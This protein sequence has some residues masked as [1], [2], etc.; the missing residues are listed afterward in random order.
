MRRIYCL[1]LSVCA[2]AALA[3][4]AGAVALAA[5][6][7][8]STTHLAYVGSADPIK[9]NYGR[10]NY[11]FDTVEFSGSALSGA[12]VLSVGDLERLATDPALDLGHESNYSFLT[13][14]AVFSKQSVSG[15]KLYDLLVHLGLDQSAPT[16][17]PVRVYAADGYV[18]TRTLAQIKEASRYN[19]Y[20]AKGDSTV[21]V[22]GVPVLLSYAAGG[23]PLIGPTGDD[24]VSRVFTW[25]DGYDV[26][27]DNAGG[28]LRLTIGQTSVDD[29]NARLNA[30]W[31]AK[32]VVG[33]PREPFHT[34]SYEPLAAS[35][36]TVDVYDSADMAEPIQTT[37]YTVG[38]IEALSPTR[39][40]GNYYDDG[41]GAFYRGADLWQLLGPMVGLPAY[42]GTAMFT[43]RSGASASVSLA[44]LRNLGGHYSTYTVAR[45][46]VL[47]DD[48]TAALTIS[49][50]R[51]LLAFTKNGYPLVAEVGDAG[52]LATGVA[53]ATVDNAGG[54]L[55]LLLPRNGVH[56]ADPVFL[57]DVTNVRLCVDIPTDVHSGDMYGP[58][59]GREISFGGDGLDAPSTLTVADLERRIE[60]MVTH[61][62]GDT[63]P[64]EGGPSGLY[65]GI[66]LLQ[67]LRSFT[68]SRGGRLARDGYRG[69][70]GSAA[71]T[72]GDLE[73]ADTPVLLAFSRGGVPLV[74][75]S[76]SVGYDDEA[77]NSGG[78]I[79][80]V[81]KTQ[82][83][84]DVASVIV[85]RKAGTWT[86]VDSPYSAYLPTALTISG[87]EV[88][89]TTI[90][91]LRDLEALDAVR[92]S[93][94]A[95]KGVGAY[96]GAVLR[97]LVRAN[98]RA[99]VSRPSK[100]TVYGR[101]GYNAQ[102]NVDTVLDGIDSSYQPGE[103]RD[104][105]LAYSKNGLP[106]V[107]SETSD[108]YSADAFNDGGPIR[109]IVENS[110]SSWVKDVRAIVVGEGEPIYAADR[111]WSTA[112]RI[113]APTRSQTR[114]FIARGSKL[115]LRAT[116]RPA[117][118]TDAV[119][120]T[121]SNR[122][123]ARV[124]AKGVV[125]ARARGAATITVKTSSGRS[126]TYRVYVT[127]RRAA[128]AIRLP[129][130]KTLRVGRATRIVPTIVPTVA[131]SRLSWRSS[132][133]RVASVDC[134]GRVGAKRRGATT[135]TVRTS[136]GKRA[137]CRVIVR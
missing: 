13:N 34:G 74:E 90:L 33:E 121:S 89:R 133:P 132:A 108:G 31:V 14:G 4:F 123:V 25:D 18:V 39:M 114:G 84:E 67:L 72:V 41:T 87:S 57:N 135:I 122:T 97:D 109:L 85:T 3:V 134:T 37:T 112:V 45:T 64:V 66:D 94:A 1:I 52:Y 95:S 23:V 11:V 124:S 20:V 49:G 79:K 136:N 17:T 93:F 28:P 12:S 126:D 26:E 115:R 111:V 131:T 29:F 82:S 27:A 128:T 61:D 106:L 104:V 88:D 46:A 137:A 38:E 71:F 80:L 36:L 119:S 32:V 15:I 42:Q 65:H 81:S 44:Y 62:Y 5:P 96:Q 118:S 101:D 68:G 2:V 116:V 69:A 47:L 51:P 110:I 8:E 63:P 86:H 120:W 6:P 48:S 50:V 40:T 53:G 103:H 24:P 58:L 16:S 30:K 59:A 91:S 76:T 70:G 129:A 83:V 7:Q 127:R 60:F 21:E 56:L 99:A 9:A 98:L 19:C 125:T 43:S 73:A 75:S 55:A 102:L 77:D 35:E 117:D 100:I 130:K 113:D 92:D 22:A 54:P 78:P 105:I 10:G 107:T